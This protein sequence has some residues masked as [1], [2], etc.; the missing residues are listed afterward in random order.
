MTQAKR[1][2]TLLEVLVALAI[3]AIGFGLLIETI[4]TSARTVRVAG[5]VG[6]AALW[7]QNRLDQ[8]GIAEPI[9]PGT[10][11]GAFNEIYRY[12]QNI[13]PYKADDSVAGPSAGDLY[14]VELKVIWGERNGERV[15]RFS[16]LRLKLKD[17]QF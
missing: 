13:T 3:F 6:H 11:S 10:K 16:T 2:F 8:L 9:E 17:G 5:D 7:A 14:L 4:A 15:E 12:E 1:G